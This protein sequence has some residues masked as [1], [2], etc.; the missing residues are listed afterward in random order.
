MQGSS[1]KSRQSVE[2]PA[3]DF[4]PARDDRPSCPD[5]GGTPIS[6]GIKWACKDCGRQWLKVMRE[7][8]LPDYAARPACPECG[9]HHAVSKG[10]GWECG[11]CGRWW[12]KEARG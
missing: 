2:I 3:L 4:A 7:R 10:S 11:G 9:A 8:N 6:Y 12:K 5:C 1:C